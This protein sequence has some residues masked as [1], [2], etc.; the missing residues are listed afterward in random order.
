MH[1]LLLLK[2]VYVD[3]SWTDKLEYWRICVLMNIETNK[4]NIGMKLFPSDKSF[5]ELAMVGGNYMQGSVSCS[6]NGFAQLS[7]S[8]DAGGIIE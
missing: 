7:W 3:V 2:L 1:H 4:F 6:Y 8:L 5:V